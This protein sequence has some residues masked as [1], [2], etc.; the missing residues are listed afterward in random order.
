MADELADKARS[1]APIARNERRR[2]ARAI[3]NFS[4]ELEVSG[5]RHAT[6]VVNLSLGG[7]LLDFEGSAPAV[8]IG[9][10]VRVT[11][12]YRGARRTVTIDGKA[13][14]WNRPSGKAP[15]LALQF[16]EVTDETADLLEEL[17]G[18]ALAVLGL[19]AVR[20]RLVGR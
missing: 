12:R 15:L 10:A 17:L 2:H 1:P 14:L 16:N 19:R 5:G 8:A 11:I 9:D 7:A 18:E 13:V 3:T 4:A 6:R 20:P